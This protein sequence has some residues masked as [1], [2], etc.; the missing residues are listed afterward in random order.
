MRYPGRFCVPNIDGLRSQFL[1]EA[2]GS[3]YSIYPA[4]TKMY[5]DLR[6]VFWW[7]GLKKDITEFVAKSLNYQQLKVTPKVGWFT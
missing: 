4:S 5:H 1:E 6:E 2:H 7:N 3:H